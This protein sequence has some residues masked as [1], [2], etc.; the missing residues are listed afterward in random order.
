ML[1]KWGETELFFSDC[2]L[3]LQFDDGLVK[4]RREFETYKE[5]LTR[6]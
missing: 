5:K 4:M 2:K 6:N 3:R 1:W